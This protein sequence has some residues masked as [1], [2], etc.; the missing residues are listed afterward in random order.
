MSSGPCA[1]ALADFRPVPI[2]IWPCCCDKVQKYWMVENLSPL[3]EA[4]LV[5]GRHAVL[6]RL[7]EPLLGRGV[8]ELLELP[9][10][11]AHIRR[12]A[13]DDGIGRADVGPRLLRQIAI[14]VDPVQRR[15]RAGDAG[16]SLMDGF[17]L[18]GGV[19]V[20]TEIHDCD[21]G[22]GSLI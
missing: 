7:R 4:E 19:A 21:S 18:F 8:G 17:G 20:A 22:H 1:L 9:G 12:A 10:R 13:V 6:P 11:P 3:T 5:A 15:L 16:R 2:Q 14:L